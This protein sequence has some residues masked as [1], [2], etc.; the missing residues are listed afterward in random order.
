MARIKR[1]SR[2]VLGTTSIGPGDVDAPS[3]DKTKAYE[4]GPLDQLALDWLPIIVVLIYEST[5]DPSTLERAIEILLRYYPRLTGRLDVQSESG[6]GG[7]SPRIADLGAGVDLWLA[8]FE[9]HDPVQAFIGEKTS[10]L[11]LFPDAGLSLLP[12]H[13]ADTSSTKA[14]TDKQDLPLLS[15]QL[16]HFPG[17]GSTLAVRL[18]HVVSDAHGFTNLLK[19]LSALYTQLDQGTGKT[20][21]SLPEFPTTSAYRPLVD[22]DRAAAYTPRLYSL[23]PPAHGPFSTCASGRVLRF[24]KTILGSL[25]ATA[26][27]SSP[28]DASTASGG[29]VSASS[30]VSTFDALSA[31]LYQSVHRARV[32]LGI[33]LSPP[34]YFTSINLRKHLQHLMPGDKPDRYFPNYTLNPFLTIPSETLCTA[35][36][37]DVAATLH[38]LPRSITPKE[39]EQTIEWLVAN[40]AA[41]HGFRFGNG[42]FMVTQWSGFDLYGVNLGS[43]P[44]RVSLPF[45]ERS[46]VDGLAYFMPTE[47]EG[48]IDVYLCLTPKVWDALE[49]GDLL[50]RIIRVSD[51]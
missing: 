9:G 33:P 1:T 6:S 39:A 19:D 28:S 43:K 38:E 49:R 16:T 18:S 24:D 15:F 50:R 5:I 26:T 17:G 7:P 12:P 40:P 2:K 14:S 3:D 46:S 31:H 23:N 22:F 41:H 48:A 8:Q 13:R 29:S 10:S 44:L 47:E 11:D 36:L 27:S 21:A 32:S 34:D 30:W 35:S 20:E 51:R 25:K 45:T 4:L 37:A 42:C